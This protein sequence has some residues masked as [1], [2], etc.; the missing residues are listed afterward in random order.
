MNDHTFVIPAYQD[1]PYLEPCILSLKNQS[2]K[3]PIIIAT[4]TPSE[5]IKQIAEKYSIEVVI[6]N[7]ANKGIADDW[8]FAL[9][10]VNTDYVTI[11]H[12]DDIYNPEFTE[13]SLRK[14]KYFKNSLI[15][16]TDYSELLDNKLRRNSL[17]LFVK[18]LF[19]F[20]LIIRPVINV[21]LFKKLLLVF[22]NPICCP[23]V[24]YNK[25]N[26]SDFSFSD[27]FSYNL[28]WF[29][30]YEMANKKGEFIFINQK[31]MKH[32]IHEDSETSKQLKT[33]GRENEERKILVILWG[34]YIGRFIYFI[35]S[36]SHK[37]NI[38]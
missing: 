14:L 9:A 8:N 33:D 35:Y 29:A 25:K 17:N 30:W 26:L 11:A 3:S 7:T 2:V 6:N 38:I 24:T 20:P 37:D 22:G 4:S 28:D 10:Q 18:R 27:K 31:L 32:R 36:L 19:F 21:S 23:S 5:Y 1:S 16:F 13:K 34:R 15:V 12:Q